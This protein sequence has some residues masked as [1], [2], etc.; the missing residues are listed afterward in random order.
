MGEVVKIDE[1]KLIEA[2]D[3]IRECCEKTAYCKD[4][5]LRDVYDGCALKS[6]PSH[7]ELEEKERPRRLIH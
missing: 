3:T 6:T 4:C 2:L 7:W 5:P 1:T